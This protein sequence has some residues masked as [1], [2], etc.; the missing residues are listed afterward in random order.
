MMAYQASE[1]RQRAAAQA[2][3]TMAR[4]PCAMFGPIGRMNG[5]SPDTVWTITTVITVGGALAGFMYA[6]V[7]GVNK[8]ID[9]VRTDLNRLHADHGRLEE[10]LR[11]AGA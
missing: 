6:L 9:D 5:M 11:T 8:R 7:G 10:R 1:V 2:D 4:N 3:G